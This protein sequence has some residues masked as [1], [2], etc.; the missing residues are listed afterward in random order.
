MGALMAW[1]EHREG[2][3]R[4]AWRDPDTGG[5]TYEKFATEAE[6]D[7]YRG[8]V[9]QA[10]GRRP[11]T[12]YEEP[13]RPARPLG[14]LPC[15]V[16]RWAE[17]WLSGV[18][19]VRD[20]TVADYRGTVERSILLYFGQMDIRDPSRTQRRPLGSVPYR[21][22][23]VTQDGPQP[24]RH[25]PL[26][27]PSCPRARASPDV[28]RQPLRPDPAPRGGPGGDALPHPPAV[29]PT[30]ERSPRFLQAR[31]HH[32]G[33]HLTSR[34]SPAA[35]ELHDPGLAAFPGPRRELSCRFAFAPVSRT[36]S[37]QDSA[38]EARAHADE[39]TLG[40]R[41]SSPKLLAPQASAYWPRAKS[42]EQGSWVRPPVGV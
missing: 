3:V 28:L 4:V 37:V 6:A 40:R 38:C 8:L 1:L 2:H 41:H 18:S 5:K 29:R 21:P 10:R 7:I 22:W 15:T 34:H 26:A 19:G 23:P 17:F 24:P 33:R 9:E 36:F 16:T 14:N 25:R 35:P 12:L 27:V 32:L 11:E 13:G 30:A 31:L 42:A 20:R 39:R